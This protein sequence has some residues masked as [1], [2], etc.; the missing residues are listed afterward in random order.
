MEAIQVIGLF[1][2]CIAIFFA[3]VAGFTYFKINKLLSTVT[4]E[5]LE[6]I[7]PLIDKQRRRIFAYLLLS[8]IF[9]IL[10]IVLSFIFNM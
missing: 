1:S 8:S 9:T 7:S 5:Q 2:G 6:R 10:T 3:L 4:E